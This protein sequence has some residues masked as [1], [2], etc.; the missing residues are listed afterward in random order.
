M[1]FIL[2]PWT[3]TKNFCQKGVTNIVHFLNLP[4]HPRKVVLN[5]FNI[6]LRIFDKKT[7]FRCSGGGVNTNYG[8]ISV[9]GYGLLED[10][11]PEQI[12]HIFRTSFA[13]FV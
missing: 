5:I 4:L 7:Q 3:R 9:E 13:S 2:V 12:Y 8:E 6:I 1:V 10:E 11:L